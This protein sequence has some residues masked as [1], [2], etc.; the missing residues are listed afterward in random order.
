MPRFVGAF[1]PANILIMV[2]P[3]EDESF[4]SIERHTAVPLP[5]IPLPDAL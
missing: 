1:F 4:L 5:T 3:I 2:V